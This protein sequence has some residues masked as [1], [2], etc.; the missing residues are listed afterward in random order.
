MIKY[1]FDNF[2]FFNGG[3]DFDFAAALWAHSNID[4]E[5][6]LQKSGP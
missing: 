4:I 2:W 1:L 5:Y 3:D 6:A